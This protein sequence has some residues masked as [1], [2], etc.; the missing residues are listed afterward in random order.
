[1]ATVSASAAGGVPLTEDKN[2]LHHRLLRAATQKEEG[3]DLS[4][5]GKNDKVSYSV[6]L[7][8]AAAMDLLPRTLLPFACYHET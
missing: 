3:R 4:N 8:D 5:Q 7:A 1:M 2:N 6:L